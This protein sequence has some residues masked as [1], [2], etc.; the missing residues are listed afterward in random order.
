MALPTSDND[1]TL[2]GWKEYIF[3][4][5]LFS[6]HVSVPANEDL[7]DRVTA[8]CHDGQEVIY[9]NGWLG[10]WMPVTNEEKAQ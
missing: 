1:C 3:D 6:L 5:A 9:I 7:D 8:F 10:D 4:C 2:M